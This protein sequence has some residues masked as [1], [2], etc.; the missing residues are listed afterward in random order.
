MNFEIKFQKAWAKIKEAKNILVVTHVRPDGDALASLCVMVELLISQN[1]NYTAFCA[2]E[3]D[4]IFSYLPHFEKVI[5]KKELINFNDYDLIISLDCGSIDRTG[6]AEEIKNRDKK[7]FFLEIDHHQKIEN[8]SDL[9]IRDSAMSATAEALYNFFKN[10]K[11]RINKNIATCILTGILTDTANF[12]YPSTSDQTIN[13]ASEM[14]VR[15]ARFPEIVHKTWYN[16]SLPSMKLWGLALSNLKINEKYNFAFSILTLEEI[17][18]IGGNDDIYDSIVGFLSNLNN[19]QGVLLLREEEGGKLKGSLRSSHPT[20]DISRLAR[21][22]GGGGHPKS[23]GF[24][25]EGK[26]EK[27]GKNY[28]IS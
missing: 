15:G 1:K 10:N 5:N 19:V 27:V 12:L 8:I 21:F 2:W 7:Q 22:F 11:I 20:A 25:V 16:K 26:L 13:I 24:L 4:K 23:S 14:L 17:K 9:E 18:S 3:V 6:L 28:V